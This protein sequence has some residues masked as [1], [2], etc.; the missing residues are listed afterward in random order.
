MEE[1]HPH[2][3]PSSRRNV[4]LAVLAAVIILGGGAVA[5]RTSLLTDLGLD[6]PPAAVPAP[7]PVATVVPPPV[8]PAGPVAPSFDVVRV[9]PNGD[10]VVAGRAAPNADVTI[11]DGGKELGHAKADDSGQFVFLPGAPLPSGGQELTL[12]ARTPDGAVSQG[13]KSVLLVVP[14]RGAAQPPVAVLT[15]PGGASRLLQAPVP[16]GPKN[17]ANAK[18]GLD[19]VD[20]DEH[21]DIRFAGTAP[22]HSTVR[23]YVDNHLAGTAEA[24]ATGRWTLTPNA[25]VP[26]GGHRVRI[27]QLGAN[28]RVVA[29]AELP[30]ERARI[31]PEAVANGRVLVQPGQSLWRLA[32]R[33]YGSGV[34]YTVIY[35]A[36][37]DQIRDPKVIYPGQVF[38]VPGED[39]KPAP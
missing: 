21:A 20:Y 1:I 2:R 37:R 23:L 28:G 22:P 6:A 5:L 27:D 30:F 12:T 31:D 33:A 29:R 18:L 10:V 14:D 26:P 11:L 25:A 24:D 34:R 8:A 16:A 4:L 3:P 35:E 13:E 15:Q 7:A 38:A 32:R 9:N 19:T 39:A 36:N 17:P